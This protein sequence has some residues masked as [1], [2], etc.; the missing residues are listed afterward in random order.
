MGIG[1]P[2]LWGMKNNNWVEMGFTKPDL[3]KALFWSLI[4]GG[5]S[6]IIGLIVLPEISTPNKLWFQ[7]GI[8]I[9]IWA[10]VASPFQEFFFRGWLQTRFEKS[11]GG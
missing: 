6:S 2:L 5:L 11:L 8:G 10:L 1:F 4:A 7:L 9:P 3:G